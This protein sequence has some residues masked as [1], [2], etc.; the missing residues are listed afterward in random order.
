MCTERDKIKAIEEYP[1]PE[2]VADVR[3]FLGLTS[4]YRMYIKSFS[5]I[6]APLFLCMTSGTQ[7]VKQQFKLIS[8]PILAYPDFKLPFI[9]ETDAT[10]EGL[11]AALSQKQN[12]QT[13]VTAYASHR[14]KKHEQSMRNFSSCMLE[15]LAKTWAIAKKFKDYLCGAKFTLLMDNNPLTHVMDSKKSIVEMG[16]LADL[17]N[18]DFDIKYRSG[19]SM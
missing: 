1:R 12:G 15:L 7:D 9:V 14:L 2:T 11:G 19:M 4:Y 5:V 13:V 6:A 17:V 16:W 8:A 3:S 10:M 18:Y